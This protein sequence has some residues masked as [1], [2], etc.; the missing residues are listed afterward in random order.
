LNSNDFSVWLEQELDLP[1][2][3]DKLNRID[4]YTST[5]QD[6]RRALLRVLQPTAK[7]A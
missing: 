2:V 7:A 4:I 6:V 1:R 3:A 5:L